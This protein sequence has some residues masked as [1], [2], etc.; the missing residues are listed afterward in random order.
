MLLLITTINL[1]IKIK[2]KEMT[3]TKN[4]V[5]IVLKCYNK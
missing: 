2:W 1:N 5:M 3:A 4:E